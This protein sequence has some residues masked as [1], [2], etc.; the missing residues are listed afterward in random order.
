MRALY[1]TAALLT[2]IVLAS[3]CTGPRHFDRRAGDVRMPS[4]PVLEPSPHVAADPEKAGTV[5]SPAPAANGIPNT[6][7]MS[8][9]SE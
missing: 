1:R 4:A 9:F 6:P 3:G 5:G 2:A 7:T 8:P